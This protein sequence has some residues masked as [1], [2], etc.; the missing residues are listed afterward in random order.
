MFHSILV[1]DIQMFSEVPGGLGVAEKKRM[2][3]NRKAAIAKLTKNR[4]SISIRTKKGA[5]K[6]DIREK[7]SVKSVDGNTVVTINTGFAKINGL[8]FR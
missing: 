3:Q 5:K 6:E 2:E 1:P 7:I 8:T 4:P